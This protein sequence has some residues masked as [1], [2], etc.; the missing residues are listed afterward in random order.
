MEWVVGSG[1]ILGVLAITLG[2]ASI[3]TGWTLPWARRRVTRP[4]IYGLGALLVGTNCVVQDLFHFRIAPSP[5]WE[6]RFFSTTALTLCG[7]ILMGVG[8]ML[9]LRR[10]S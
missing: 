1:M 10:R 4:R 9:P 3:R 8:Q 2:T 5:P 7:L 6:I